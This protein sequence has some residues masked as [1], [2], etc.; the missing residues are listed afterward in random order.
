L[1]L[2]AGEAIESLHGAN[3]EEHYGVLAEHFI[4]GGKLVE[5]AKYSRLAAK[6]AQHSG[7]LSGAIDYARKN[8]ECL[9]R[10]AKSVEDEKREIDSRAILAGYLLKIGQP[11]EAKE[12]VAPIMGRALELDHRSSW[13]A[14]YGATGISELFDEDYQA[15]MR[16]L[17]KVLADSSEEASI[18][19]WMTAY[20]LGIYE[21]WRCEFERS[22]ELL[23]TTIRMSQATGHL[24]GVAIARATYSIRYL[25]EG[26]LGRALQEWKQARAAANESHDPTAVVLYHAA[27]GMLRSAQ[28][29][30]AEAQEHLSRGLKYTGEA[31]QSTWRS[32]VLAYLGDTLSGVG[33]HREA[34]I[35]YRQAAEILENEG[36]LPSW[37]AAHNV[38]AA[39]SRA[40]D[41]GTDIDLDRC[42]RLREMNRFRLFE[43]LMARNIAQISLM[44]A[45][46]DLVEA[47]RLIEQAIAADATNG[48]QLE[49]AKD[50][51]CRADL[52]RLAVDPEKMRQDL[53]RARDIYGSCGADGFVREID[54]CIASGTAA[55]T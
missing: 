24:E 40:L 45:E 30:H 17:E 7:A 52:H 20:Y 38:R 46:P 31:A 18:W 12:V 15:A 27:I 13:S 37:S 10:V 43:G 14:I 3:L 1:H 53:I 51:V 36:A 19:K 16:N 54:Q 47:R 55:L 44:A 5:G 42:H 49:L 28:G 22:D 33:R 6:R 11:H 26:Q 4:A 41:G 23:T 25:C 48:V 2:R 50:H 34:E 9:Q 39:R 32:M 29:L 8:V 21:F 35:H